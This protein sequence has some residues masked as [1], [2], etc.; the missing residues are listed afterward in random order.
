MEAAHAFEAWVIYQTTQHY[1]P[2][3]SIRHSHHVTASNPTKKISFHR[4]IISCV[5]LII[6]LMERAVKW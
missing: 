4:L 2:K 3:D 5:P 1:V 6:K